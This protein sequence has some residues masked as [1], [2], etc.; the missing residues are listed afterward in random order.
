MRAFL[1]LS[2]ILALAA[3]AFVVA[4]LWRSQV[5]RL[6]ALVAIGLPLA[7]LGLYAWTSDWS[8]DQPSAP[9]ATNVPGNLEEVVSLLAR[10]LEERPDDVMG[11]KLLGRS[12]AVMGDYPGARD[13][14][15]EAYTRSAGRDVEATAGYAEALMLNDEREL[16]GRA[17][18]LFEEA[19]ALDPADARALWY[20]G[21]VAWRRGDI[22]TARQRW[23]ALQGQE[24]PAEISRA[25]AERLAALDSAKPSEA[26]AAAGEGI[27]LL[28]DVAPAL[29][30]RVPAGG[31]LYVIARTAGAGPPLAVARHGLAGWPRSLRLTDADA[32]L[33]GTSL[34]DQGT[35]RITVRI[36]RSGQPTAA[37]GDLFGEV[38]YDPAVAGPVAL[39]ID[40]IVP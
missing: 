4:P 31:A 27:A 11:W 32:M 12:R 18:R 7:A 10:R 14:F 16:E 20:G 25:V 21:I 39:T 28:V 13:A 19:L 2:A 37:S 5:R 40:R 9:T 38:G 35:L 30:G 22:D 36:S 17:G 24:L 8:W 1:V 6:A 23:Q 3:A 33:P 15:G 29:S 34:Q 26:A